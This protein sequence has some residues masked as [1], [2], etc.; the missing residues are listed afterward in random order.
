MALLSE[1]AQKAQDL[2]RSLGRMDGVWVTSPLPLADGA[3]LRFQVLDKHKNELLQTLTDWGWEP[4]FVQILPRIDAATFKPAAIYEIDLPP[5]RQSVVDDRKD[6][7]R[8]CRG[9]EKD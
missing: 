8:G 4:R 7:W 3:R 5:E 9:E 6:L 2:A 1:R